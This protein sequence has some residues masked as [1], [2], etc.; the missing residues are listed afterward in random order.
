M[1]IRTDIFIRLLYA[2]RKFVTAATVITSDELVNVEIKTNIVHFLY[3]NNC[4]KNSKL[5]ETRAK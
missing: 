2:N 4:H 3:K 1:F 5:K